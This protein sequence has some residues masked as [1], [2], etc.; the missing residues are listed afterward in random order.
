MIV[1]LGCVGAGITNPYWFGYQ[2]Y[3]VLE[4]NLLA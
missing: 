3:D 1:Y 4:D 2:E